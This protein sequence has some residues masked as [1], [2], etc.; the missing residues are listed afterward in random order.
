[1][2]NYIKFPE[3]SKTSIITHI[4][5]NRIIA[6]LVTKELYYEKPNIM[7][8]N[9]ALIDCLQQVKYQGKKIAFPLI[10]EGLDKLDWNITRNTIKILAETIEVEVCICYIDKNKYKDTMDREWIDINFPIEENKEEKSQNEK[11]EIDTDD[12]LNDDIDSGNESIDS[13]IE[14]DKELLDTL[15]VLQVEPPSQIYE[16]KSEYK[17]LFN[18]IKIN[19]INTNQG[20]NTVPNTI[21]INEEVILKE[22]IDDKI[23][24]EVREWI[25]NKKL[26]ESKEH[27]VNP[28]LRKYATEFELLSI[29]EDTN[30]LQILETDEIVLNIPRKEYKILLPFS[31]IL[32]IFDVTHY[33]ELQGHTGIQK[34]YD[35]IRQTFYFPG[36]FKWIYSLVKDCIDCQTQKHVSKHKIQTAKLLSPG[37]D[38]TRPMD[39]LHIDYKGPI[40]PKSNGNQY[41]LVIVDAFSR[42]V[43][44]Y[45]TRT[46]SSKHTIE[47]LKHYFYRFGIPEKLVSD[48][49]SSFVSREFID[50][51]NIHGVKNAL[52]SGY[53]PQA[54]GQVE[55]I[56]QHI[57]SYLR[58]I[59]GDNT[60]KWSNLINQWC[61]AYNTSTISSLGE[62]PYEIVFGQKPKVPNQFKLGTIRKS[63][64][65]CKITNNNMCN[66][67]GN[68]CHDNN[69]ELTHALQVFLNKKPLTKEMMT[70]EEEITEIYNKV[71]VKSKMENPDIYAKRNTQFSGC[72]LK[73]GQF[74]LVENKQFL[75]G[76]SKKL[77]P[78]RQGIWKV[79]KA[80][81][82]TTY[83]IQHTKTKEVLMRHRNL[84]LPYIPKE[85]SVPILEKNY[86]TYITRWKTPATQIFKP[87]NPDDYE[88]TE[89]II[90]DETQEI[91]NENEKEKNVT[92]EIPEP[93]PNKYRNL[94]S[95]DTESDEEIQGR[96]NL[97]DIN[98]RNRNKEN[99]NRDQP[100]EEPIEI[101]KSNDL[102]DE[103]EIN[104]DQLENI[105]EPP[106]ITPEPELIN[107]L[108][109]EPEL[110]NDFINEPELINDL[111]NE[112][113]LTIEPEITPIKKFTPIRITESKEEKIPIEEIEEIDFNK[114]ELN[115]PST[116]KYNLRPRE[117]K[118]KS[119][120]EPLKFILS[121]N[122]T[123]LTNP[124]IFTQNPKPIPE[125]VNLPRNTTQSISPEDIM[126]SVREKIP[127]QAKI[128]T[129]EIKDSVINRPLPDLPIE[130]HKNISTREHLPRQAKNKNLDNKESRIYKPLPEI[131]TEQPI[132][133]SVRKKVIKQLE[134]ETIRKSSRQETIRLEKERKEKEQKEK[135][136]QYEKDYL[137]FLEARM[138]AADKLGRNKKEQE[139]D[140][141]KRENKKI[142]E[143]EKL[144][145]EKKLISEKKRKEEIKAKWEE[146]LKEEK[147]RRK[148]K[149]KKQSN[150]KLIL[151]D[152]IND[153]IKLQNNYETSEDESYNEYSENNEQS[154]DNNYTTENESETE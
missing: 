129:T 45:P 37:R 20:I 119:I 10:G 117:V 141:I 127:R 92:F 130:I 55:T 52:L 83:Y 146:E 69:S 88:P 96:Y 76:I 23:L 145:L 1:M 126:P 11:N 139:K 151:Q 113:D 111:I 106:K 134:P 32:P 124:E 82:A 41:I 50:F 30:L 24:K 74:V 58:C 39:T 150:V 85:E 138:K 93:G 35:M 4:P 31:L 63:N 34:T 94:E 25:E 95:D 68:H 90:N 142:K 6:N 22:Q 21:E 48:R 73:P 59:T 100:E 49:G 118:L 16:A 72:I 38:V 131:P 5:T 154:D 61:F 123:K 140:K 46:C 12:E 18:E 78:I 114:N 8:L 2:R 13:Y 70:R 43:Q 121:E 148:E 64:R 108:I 105:N 137:L 102:Q 144:K 77:Q 103:I 147:R 53:N 86:N 60:N 19:H 99:I 56:N 33:G 122:I 17:R 29:N 120:T 26:P 125:K 110:I 36:L 104:N 27:R 14:D 7:N 71:Y 107:D 79:I 153:L 3:I 54:N 97:R 62:T 66:R 101:I 136:L 109:N 42:F 133:K 149:S 51:C 91:I 143:E 98:N 15:Y 57:T 80:V 47:A 152:K 84:L 40:N 67:F 81:N 87:F 28:V 65:N 128:K 132:E 115:E 75:K 9:K 116:S 112:Q 89:E 135:E 44:A